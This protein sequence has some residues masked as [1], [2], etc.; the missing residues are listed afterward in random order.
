MQQQR[1]ELAFAFFSARPHSAGPLT[2]VTL[3]TTEVRAKY[4][5]Q[6]SVLALIFFSPVTVS[7]L[8]TKLLKWVHLKKPHICSFQIYFILKQ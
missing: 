7:L 6:R 1:S 3:V 4:A 5:Q 8:K 2:V